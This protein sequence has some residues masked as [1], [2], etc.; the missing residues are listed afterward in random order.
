MLDGWQ[1]SARQADFRKSLRMRGLL[2]LVGLG[3]GTL[4]LDLHKLGIQIPQ[5]CTPLWI[6]YVG[7]VCIGIACTLLVCSLLV[8]LSVGRLQ[9]NGQLPDGTVWHLLLHYL[10]SGHQAFLDEKIA[11]IDQAGLADRRKNH[12]F[13]KWFSGELAQA[14]ATVNHHMRRKNGDVESVANALLS[15]IAS[16]AEE[17]LSVKRINVNYMH[18]YAKDDCPVGIREKA[19]FQAEDKSRYSHYLSLL[20]YAYEDGREGFALPVEA[21]G[22]KA[23]LRLLPGAPYAYRHKQPVYVEDTR[24]IP[25]P[26]GLEA[27]IISSQREYFGDKKFRS[28][29]S[30]PIIIEGEPIGVL[31]MDAD[32]PHA[33]GQSEEE[34]EGIVTLILPFC[35]LLSAIVVRGDSHGSDHA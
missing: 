28:F 21:V 4:L 13:L 3:V 7:G 25:Y 18:A 34:K 35:G 20:Y 23:D 1:R 29:L 27:E 2:W 24:N 10:H 6:H 19:R 14:V 31:N 15:L 16:T 17:Y 11:L 5:D 32:K 30:V 22:H 9:K 26:K 12:D 8:W 33:F